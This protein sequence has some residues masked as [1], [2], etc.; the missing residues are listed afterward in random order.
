[1]PKTVNPESHSRNIHQRLLDVMRECTYIK[2]DR[3]KGVAWLITSHDVVTAKV[4][5]YLVK[6]RITHVP[7]IVSYKQDGN[8]TE[9]LVKTTFFNVDNPEDNVSCTTLGYGIDSQDKGCGKAMSY[10]V[11]FALLK[12]LGLET[13]EDADYECIDHVPETPSPDY[14]VSETDWIFHINLIKEF[15]VNRDLKPSVVNAD[16]KERFKK[17][18]REMVK[19]ELDEVHVWLEKTYPF[20]G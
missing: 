13:G 19:H 14:L 11:K 5:P 8:R 4:N 9:M 18:L 12:I 20:Q 17:T 6:H 1:M 2:K 16:I 7:N 10:A 3:V 15:C